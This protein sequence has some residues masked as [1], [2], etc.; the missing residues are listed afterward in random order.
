MNDLVLSIATH[1]SLCPAEGAKR[2]GRGIKKTLPADSEQFANVLAKPG[3][4][5]LKGQVSE[6]SKESD[7]KQYR[8]LI[9]YACAGSNPVLTDSF[10]APGSPLSP[11][12]PETLPSSCVLLKQAY[13]QQKRVNWRQRPTGRVVEIPLPPLA[14][15]LPLHT[16]PDCLLHSPVYALLA[17][18]GMTGKMSSKSGKGSC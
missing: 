15:Q 3:Q 9:R 13:L 11:F 16:C 4:A 8:H 1:T 6:W 12:L 5:A 18:C 7:L 2:G 17:V 10:A 14:Q